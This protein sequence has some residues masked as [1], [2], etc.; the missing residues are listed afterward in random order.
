M[1]KDIHPEYREV[2]FHDTSVDEYFLVR[3]TLQTDQTKE[4]TDGNTYP[5]CPLDVSSASHPFYT[6]KQKLV[7]TGGR[8]DRFR[9]R[10]GN[11][12]K[13]AASTEETAVEEEVMELAADSEEVTEEAPEATN[14]DKVSKEESP[15]EDN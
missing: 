15:P 4:W 13:V 6:G 9:K 7:D 2:L 8:V 10:F 14:A 5:Y 3:S 1:R 12:S 11:K